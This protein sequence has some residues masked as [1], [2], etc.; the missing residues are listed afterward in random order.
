MKNSLLMKKLIICICLFSSLLGCRESSKNQATPEKEHD[1]GS[2]GEGATYQEGKG[3]SLMKETEQSLGVEIVD[4]TEQNIQSKI[5]LTAQVYRSASEKSKKTAGEQQGNAY[6]TAL[7]S[8]DLSSRLTDQTKVSYLNP[9]QNNLIL[10]G[11]LWKIISAQ[12]SGLEN[13]ELLLEFP[14]P[15]KSMTI[16]DFLEIDLLPNASPSKKLVIPHSARLKTSTGTF[17]FVKNGEFL[18]RTEIKT[19]IE[20]EEWIEIVEGLYEGDQV[21]VK[22]VEALYMIELRATKGGGHCH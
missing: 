3:I 2:E 10:V 22:P 13:T 12:A 17:A 19:G 20:N 11:S 6:A 16:G 4:L 14:D 8:S 18:L 15:E 1:H 5:H 21:A 7:I 9:Q